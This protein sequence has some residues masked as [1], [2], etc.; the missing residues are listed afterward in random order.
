[1]SGGTEQ[2]DLSPFGR[3]VIQEGD[4]AFH[5]NSLF[6][7]KYANIIIDEVLDVIET[8]RNNSA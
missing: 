1:L 5:I 4:D 7:E 3:F 8:Y 2:A 6:E